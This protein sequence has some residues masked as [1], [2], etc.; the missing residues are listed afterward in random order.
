MRMCERSEQIFLWGFLTEKVYQTPV[1]TR[2]DL[3]NR[4]QEVFALITPD[5]LR[6]LSSNIVRRAELC[7]EH[8]GQHFEQYLK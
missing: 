1:H 7:V 3:L 2:E 6:K 8:A 5:I 4:L